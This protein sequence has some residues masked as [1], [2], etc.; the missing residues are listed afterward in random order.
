MKPPVMKLVPMFAAAGVVALGALP[1]AANAS[2]QTAPK[3]PFHPAASQ[4][5]ATLKVNENT[6]ASPGGKKTYTIQKTRPITGEQTTVPVLQTKQ[7]GTATWLDVRLPGR[8]KPNQH[9]PA[10]GWIQARGVRTWQITWHIYVT[11]GPNTSG[12]SSQRRV[13]VY[14]NGKLLK[15]W[16][17]VPGAPGRVTPLGDYFVE[18]NINE[19]YKFPGGP[20]AL[21]TSARSHTYTSFDNGPGQVAIHGMSGG[22]QAKPGTAVS[23]GCVRLPNNEI[24]WL[25]HQIYPGTPVTIVK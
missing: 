15:S 21:A 11:V 2:R 24:T 9:P 1:T 20:F 6:Y 10:T 12:Y 16:Q 22:L 23:H 17:A 18:E 13:W 14:N 5:V 7:Q 8:A 4:E 3:S 19:G 25:A